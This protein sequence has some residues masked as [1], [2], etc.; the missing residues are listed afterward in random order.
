MRFLIK[1]QIKLEW[2]NYSQLCPLKNVGFCIFHQTGATRR[3]G[4]FDSLKNTLGNG[5]ESTILVECGFTAHLRIG[6][7]SDLYFSDSIDSCLSYGQAVYERAPHL[8]RAT[9]E[10]VSAH[11]ENRAQP[12]DNNH[13]LL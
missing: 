5:N 6:M 8:A 12:S 4:G 1:S 7:I 2:C 9:P 10:L 11:R 3:C 13:N